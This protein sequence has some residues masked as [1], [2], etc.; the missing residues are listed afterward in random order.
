M[1]L[2]DN[3]KILWYREGMHLLDSHCHIDLPVFKND[4]DETLRACKEAG[5]HEMILPGVCQ[6]GWHNLLKLCTAEVG[7]FP[8][9]GLHPM[10][11]R[12]H[13]EAHLDELSQHIQNSPVIALGEI[14]LDYFVKDVDH[15]KQQELFE[16][17]LQLAQSASLPILLHVRKA[18][19]QVLATLR[20]NPFNQGG[21][22]HAFNGSLQQAGQY[23]D[24]GFKI[25]FCGTVTYDR[26]TKIRRL[27]VD[28]DLRDMVIETDS[29]DLP[30][31]PHHGERN[32]PANLIEVVD[33][34]AE[35]RDQPREDIAAV[36]RENARTLLGL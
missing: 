31:A 19:D 26:A 11:L 21:I 6:S 5:V 24:M 7:L 1:Q 16:S 28:L 12:H 4:L 10:Y 33:C 32:E 29:P 3:L 36:T 23:I 22:V 20:R 27:A 34:L 13:T 35:L 14:G 17:Q 18:H 15:N 25:S 8:A 2:Y 9:I 30:P